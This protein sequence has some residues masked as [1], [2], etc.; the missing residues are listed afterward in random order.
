MGPH[1]AKDVLLRHRNCG[2]TSVHIVALVAGCVIVGSILWDAFEALILPRTPIR[3]LRLTRLFYRITWRRWCQHA[4]LVRSDR[5]R[6]RLLAVYGP[7][8]VI[9]LLT[10]WASGLV[11][12]FALLQW[13]QRELL[14]NLTGSP[15]FFDDLYMS[16]TTIFALGTGDMMPKGRGGRLLVVAETGSSLVLLTMVFAYLP[17]L[18]QSFA[19][20]EIRVTM[21]DAWAG[22]PP[23]AAEILRRVV[24]SGD[25][26]SL[27]AF[28]ADWEQ[29][30]ADLLESQLS[31]P[32]IAYFRSQHSHQSWVAALATVL[33]LS[34]L[35]QVGIDGVPAWRAHLCFA[36][37]RHAAVDLAQM[38]ADSP[39]PLRDRLPVPEL[40]AMRHELEQAGLRL[41]CSSEADRE[42]SALRRSYE[43]YL[44][45]MS[46]RLMMPLSDWRRVSQA[47]D[48]WQTEPSRD[49]GAHR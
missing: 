30:C 3:T 47:P 7:L 34:A 39:A 36:I 6:E 49:G 22:S 31:Y 42:L 48:N 25:P 32:A 46:S 17:I 23:S 24:T 1:E 27:D 11:L 26:S 33:D 38:L 12:G 18:Y 29:W 44:A 45:A 43:P 10:L 21:L 35:V 2:L 9:A 8:S 28:F 40:A 19:R 4:R 5:R 20:R 13:S 37:A 15:H 16:A 14:V 41:N